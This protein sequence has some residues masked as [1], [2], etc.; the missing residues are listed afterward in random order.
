METAGLELHGGLETAGGSTNVVQVK[1]HQPA[2]LAVYAKSQKTSVLWV[3]QCAAHNVLAPTYVQS[4]AKCWIGEKGVLD[5]AVHL[6]FLFMEPRIGRF[7]N[8]IGIPLAICIY[9]KKWNILKGVH[10]IEQAGVVV[11]PVHGVHHQETAVHDIS[12]V[13]PGEKQQ[14][15]I[16]Y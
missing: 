14:S 4:I 16:I 12:I 13:V 11:E 3:W 7:S 8:R 6:E 9:R 10:A 5:Y 15:T 1:P 2:I